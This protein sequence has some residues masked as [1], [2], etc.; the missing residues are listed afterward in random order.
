MK[1]A[2]LWFL[3]NWFANAF[4]PIAVRLPNWYCFKCFTFHGA[5]V[6]MFLSDGIGLDSFI[7]AGALS[8]LASLYENR[9]V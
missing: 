9:G 8:F 7:I 2:V 6:I 4:E 5:M 1:L 3:I